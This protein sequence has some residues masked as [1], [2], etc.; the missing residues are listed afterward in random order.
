MQ[1]AM[2]P[3]SKNAKAASVRMGGSPCAPRT[4]G[5]GLDQSEHVLTGLSIEIIVDNGFR[6]VQSGLGF[7]GRICQP[8]FAVIP[9]AQLTAD[10]QRDA[11]EI[12]GMRAHTVS[13]YFDYL[14]RIC[15]SLYGRVPRTREPLHIGRRCVVLSGG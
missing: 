15:G 9:D 6:H 11:G 7:N 12:R 4:P 13:P 8:H 10:L 2:I 3:A 1:P 14:P 5:A